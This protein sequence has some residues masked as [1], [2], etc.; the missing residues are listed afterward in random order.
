MS[1]NLKEYLGQ[2]RLYLER[3]ARSPARYLY[4]Q[5][6][7]VLASWIPTIVGI[8]IR[9]ILYRLILDMDGYAAIER[10]VRLRFAGNVHLIETRFS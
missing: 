7:M 10:N 2:V 1:A 5:L 4:E 6:V 3:Q 9:A 8:G